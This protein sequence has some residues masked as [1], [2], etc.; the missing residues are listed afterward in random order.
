MKPKRITEDKRTRMISKLNFYARKMQ[1]ERVIEAGNYNR[2][3]NQ[4]DSIRSYCN[5]LESNNEAMRIGTPS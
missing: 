1:S 2:I 4:I 5:V 3:K